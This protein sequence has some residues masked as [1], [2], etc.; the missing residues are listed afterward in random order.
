M[1]GIIILAAGNSSRLGKPKQN[2][3]YQGKTL[4]QHAVSAALHS[5]CQPV[6]VVLGAI[7]ETILPQADKARIT[8]LHNPGWQQGMSASIRLGIAELQKTEGI[9]NAVIMLCDQPFVGA[10][11]I[12]NILQK[13]NQCNKGI[14]ASAY[15]N[16]L[17]VPVLF[18]KKYFAALL[19]LTGDEGAKKLLTDYRDDIEPVNFE[20]GAIDID[21]MEDYQGLVGDQ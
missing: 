20:Q 2:L 10:A 12:Q 11:L 8:I 4:L 9:E 1:T 21:T 3:V 5:G 18:N 13:Y 16:T 15:N 7:M 19:E 14:I 6:I 17:G